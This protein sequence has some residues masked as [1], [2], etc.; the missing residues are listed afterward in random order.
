M[1]RLR[2]LPGLGPYVVEAIVGSGGM[3]VVYRGR[4]RGTGALAALKTV[5]VDSGEHLAA[6]RR[7][8]QVLAGLHHPGIVRILDHGISN[9]APWYAMDLVQGRPLS[10]LLRAPLPSETEGVTGGV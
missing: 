2:P 10:S 1:E 6:F 7:E 3:G 8:V 9:G 5:Q 4:H